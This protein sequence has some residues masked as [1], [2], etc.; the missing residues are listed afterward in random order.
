MEYG[1]FLKIL[2]YGILKL[3]NHWFLPSNY[4]FW[5]IWGT[6]IWVE[7]DIYVKWKNM[8]LSVLWHLVFV[9]HP[10]GVP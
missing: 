4:E 3:L 10:A 1:G 6:R 2:K 7:T 5:M 8:V 9:F